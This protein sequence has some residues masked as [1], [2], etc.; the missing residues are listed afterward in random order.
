MTDS[1]V[2]GDEQ[3]M[4]T[5]SNLDN[6]GAS[7]GLGAIS[8]HTVTIIDDSPTVAFLQASSSG[9]ET[10]GTVNIEVVLNKSWPDPV[11]VNYALNTGASTA[12]SP[13]DFTLGGSGT[14]TFD[15]VTSRFIPVNLV[16]DDYQE[17]GE[18]IVVTLSNPSGNASLA[19]GTEVRTIPRS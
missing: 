5:L 19:I 9:E 11:T 7:V 13:E 10:D 12:D 6:G 14:L 17:S 2:E 3:F 15:G 8:Q 1:L 16:N 4:L 18:T